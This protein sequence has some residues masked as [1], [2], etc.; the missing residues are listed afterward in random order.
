MSDW[1]YKQLQERAKE[2]RLEK[3]LKFAVNVKRNKLCAFVEA[4]STSAG[5]SEE[6]ASKEKSSNGEKGVGR[7]SRQEA[8]LVQMRHKIVKQATKSLQKRFTTIGK[9]LTAHIFSSVTL[10]LNSVDSINEKDAKT[11]DFWEEYRTS[12]PTWE[13]FKIGMR[14]FL[15]GEFTSNPFHATPVDEETIPLLA[16]LR[17]LIDYN[18]VSVEGQ[19]GSCE[20]HVWAPITRINTTTIERGYTQVLSENEKEMYL[21]VE[22]MQRLKLQDEVTIVTQHRIFGSKNFVPCL[23][24]DIDA[25][26]QDIETAGCYTGSTSWEDTIETVKNMNAEAQGVQSGSSAF[27]LIRSKQCVV[28]LDNLLLQIAK[29]IVR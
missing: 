14:K 26:K 5:S 4:H 27:L 6:V 10:L 12:L 2:I 25:D 23:T 17:S 7:S 11:E 16:N 19:P 28:D 21:F 9:G 24:Y 13:N 29:A 18:F 1:T 20:R 8:D 22:S 15:D 3:N